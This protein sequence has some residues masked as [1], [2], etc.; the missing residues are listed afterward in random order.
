MTRSW[1]SES[2]S[3]EFEFRLHLNYLLS[4]CLLL[5]SLLTLKIRV[6]IPMCGFIVRLRDNVF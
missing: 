5:L 3:A 4:V 2:N 6:V 1:A